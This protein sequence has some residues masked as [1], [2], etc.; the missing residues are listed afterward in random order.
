MTLPV[1]P[2]LISVVVKFLYY[3]RKLPD[4]KNI[5]WTDFPLY[6]DQ[7]IS[8]KIYT[9]IFQLFK[10][11][12]LFL[13]NIG[14]DLPYG[15]FVQDLITNPP[16][17]KSYSNLINLFRILVIFFHIWRIIGTNTFFFCEKRKTSLRSMYFIKPKLRPNEI[18]N[19]AN[20]DSPAELSFLEISRKFLFFL[21]SFTLGNCRNS[22]C[23]NFSS[24]AILTNIFDNQ[25]MSIKI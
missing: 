24:L 8:E 1:Q 13:F 2:S 22:N 18:N 23:V 14:G 25:H 11:K 5:N 21:C 16:C 7:F 4:V 19:A 3:D 15:D 17:I 12:I 6:P 10:Y 9:N 20:S